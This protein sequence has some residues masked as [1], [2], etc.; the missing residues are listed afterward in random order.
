MLFRVISRVEDVQ[1]MHIFYTEIGVSSISHTVYC[2]NAL[3][4][5]FFEGTTLSL[6]GWG[7]RY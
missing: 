7:V 2:D 3:R 5:P 4:A 6:R 1:V